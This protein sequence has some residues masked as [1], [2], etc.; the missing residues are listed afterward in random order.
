MSRPLPCPAAW[1]LFSDVAA[2]QERE[3]GAE[4]K[5]TLSFGK[6]DAGTVRPVPLLSEATTWGGGRAWFS[7]G[8]APWGPSPSG[9]LAVGF[10]CVVWTPGKA[11]SGCCSHVLHVGRASQLCLQSCASI[12]VSWNSFI[13]HS[14]VE[15]H[16]VSGTYKSW[17]S[18]VNKQEDPRPCGADTLTRETDSKYVSNRRVCVCV[19]HHVC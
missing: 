19:H 9:M 2:R 13:Q 6:L 10:W 18:T 3:E 1:L 17:E 5:P 8:G 7:A 14:F 12:L 15:Q 4:G 16:H 11:E